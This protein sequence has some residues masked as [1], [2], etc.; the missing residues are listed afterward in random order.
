MK[1][2]K[3]ITSTIILII[4]GFMTKLL[5]MVIK[6]VMTRLIGTE[7][8]GLYM[9]I[10]PTFMLFIA[11]TTFGFPTAISKLIAEEKRN[12]KNL[13]FSTI[14]LIII[15]NFITFIFIF[16][17]SKFISNNLLNEPRTFYPL[18]SIAF[19]LPF[20]S[21]SSVLRGYFFGKQIM[22]AHVTSNVVEDIIRLI[23][24]VIGLPLFLKKGLE[25]AVSFIVLSNIIS[26]LT[27]I[28]VLFFFL[29]KNFKLKKDDFKIKKNNIKDIMGISIPTTTSRLIGTIGSFFEPIILTNFLLKNGYSNSF[30][31]N[32]YGILN[33]YV[34][35]L[36]LL[37]SF[38][39]LAISQALLPVISKA[40]SSNNIKYIKNKIKQ[41]LLFS[42]LIGIPATLIF[43]LIPEIPLK[44]IY[45]T[46]SGLKYIRILSIVC[47]F[48]YIQS[49]LTS[50]LQAMNK[51][52]LAMEGTIIGILIKIIVLIITCNLKIGL[53]GLVI[54][55]SVNILYVT[56]HHIVVLN[57]TFKSLK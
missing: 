6:I 20:I 17:C 33:G 55:S 25:F 21:I 48:H 24:I 50:A 2:N 57:K 40:Y 9:L 1:K 19:V 15:I 53:W 56:I 36:I 8:T 14:P 23:T 4:G 47:L 27:S 35:P 49:P 39:T 52:K 3:F 30:I 29:P 34:M 18:L 41:G 45:N 51:S 54:A 37:P 42:L 38:F 44:L 22:I 11:I 16:F 10:L 28:F 13:V 12:N 7:G 31:I 5:S 46:T 32:E 26:E 43:V